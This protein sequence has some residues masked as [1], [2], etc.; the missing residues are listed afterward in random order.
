MLWGLHPVQ[1]KVLELL[2]GQAAGA[3]VFVFPDAVE[4][5]LPAEKAGVAASGETARALLAN[6]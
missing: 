2:V 3:L 1:R 6:L 5:L 4:Q